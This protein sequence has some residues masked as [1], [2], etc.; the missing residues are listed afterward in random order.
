M[1][2]WQLFGRRRRYFLHTAIREF[3]RLLLCCCCSRA[4]PPSARAG[5]QI[6]VGGSLVFHLHFEPL[7]WRRTF[8]KAQHFSITLPCLLLPEFA[9]TNSGLLVRA[10]G[11]NGEGLQR[12][13]CRLAVGSTLQPAA[14]SSAAPEPEYILKWSRQ[15]HCQKHWPQLVADL[16][17]EETSATTLT[18]FY[19]DLTL[20]R[21][22]KSNENG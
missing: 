1:T 18:C 21:H 6:K 4:H 14:N 22:F 9:P 2:P 3:M 20:V 5:R 17:L 8:G 19:T 15:E 11:L 12:L 16:G 7:I 10:Q 13:V